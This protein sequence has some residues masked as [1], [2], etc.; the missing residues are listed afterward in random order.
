M[1]PGRIFYG[2]TMARSAIPDFGKEWPAYEYKPWPKYVG[3]DAEGEALIAKDQDEFDA[4]KPLAAYPKVMGTDK[5]GKEVIANIPRDL[6]WKKAQVVK[7]PEDPAVVAKR[8]ADAA[9]DAAEVKRKAAAYDAMMAGQDAKKEPS[10]PPVTAQQNALT[11]PT[12][13]KK[14]KAA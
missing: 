11:A 5:N 7:P 12:G 8:E 13:L 4:M 14:S 9:F 6:E 3:L 10:A 2:E 1:V